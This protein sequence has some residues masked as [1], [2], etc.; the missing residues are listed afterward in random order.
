MEFQYRGLKADYEHLTV[1]EEEL[2]RQLERLRRENPRVTAVTDRPARMGDEV[3]LDYAGFCGGVQFP[4][5][6][7]QNQTLT[8]GSGTFIP[9]FEEQLAG[10]LPGS[11]VTVRVTFPQEYP[12]PSLAGQAAEFRCTVREIREKSEYALDDTFAREVGRCA[13]AQELRE[14]MRRT[15][16]S[17]FDERA[18]NEL[19]ERLL[20]AAA[21]T[22]DFDPT[23]AELE[24]ALD[25][26][27][28]ALGA[29][30]AQ[31]SLSLEDYCRF[32]GESLDELREGMRADAR[33]MLRQK[34]TVEKIAELEKLEADEASV[35]AALAEICREN[36]VTMEQLQPYYDETFAAAVER[37][38]LTNKA[39][40]L[41]RG[42]ADVTVREV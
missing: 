31:R 24:T 19:R 33:A 13:T 28:Q 17:V 14:T 8:L 29:Q 12:E 36:G 32:T 20:R 2:D 38:V 9:G 34:K 7:A 18:E 30:L 40:E 21:A 41:L 16:Q 26:Q 37:R 6:T 35:S 15:L 1:T 3:L 25:E 4:G 27:L 22:L 23:E 39:L 42:A 10:A 5:G 11:E